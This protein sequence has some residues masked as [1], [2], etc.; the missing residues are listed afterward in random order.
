MEDNKDMEITDDDMEIIGVHEALT[1]AQKKAA[2]SD[3]AG[4][5]EILEEVI[6][7]LENSPKYNDPG[8]EYHTFAAPIE[9]VLYVNEHGA[10]KRFETAGEAF[11]TLYLTYGD[12]LLGMEDIKGAKAAFEKAIKWNP[13]NPNLR[14]EYAEAFRAEGDTEGFF[15]ASVDAHKTAYTKEYLGR[16]YRNIGYYFIEKEMWD[17]AMAAYVLSLNLDSSSK[18]AAKEIDYIQEKTDGKTRI[19]SQE[20][21]KK[22][23]EEHGFPTEANDSIVGLS[24]YYGHKALDDGR[25]DVAQYFLSIAY[26]LTGDS[27]IKEML[28]GMAEGDGE[29][30]LEESEE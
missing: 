26:D 17:E 15:N 23:G 29:E 9:Q 21:I 3:Y 8:T 6:K 11:A 30:E 7:K 20:D 4:A 5:K 28:E 19:P 10:D 2:V 16:I 14:L 1:E 12:L 25:K 13:V 27:N 22:V 18:D 24:A